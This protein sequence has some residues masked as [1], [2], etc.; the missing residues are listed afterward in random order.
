MTY[1]EIIYTVEVPDGTDAVLVPG[2]IA[3]PHGTIVEIGCDGASLDFGAEATTGQS[4]GIV[5]SP[6][7]SI[8]LRLRCDAGQVAPYPDKMFDPAPSRFTRAADDLVIEAKDA[9]GDL[10]GLARAQA[11]ARHTAE[12]FSYGHPEAR[13][14]DGC[15]VVPALGCGLTEGSC[16]DI[17]TYFLAALR[18]SGIEAGYVT[19]F[20]FPQEKKDHCTDGHCWVV[21]RINGATHEWDIAHHL[22]L[23][24]RDIAPALNPKPGQRV[25]C[26]HSM[27]L[28][29]P[30]LGGL[31]LK[32]L[33]EPVAVR[34][35]QVL[36]FKEPAIRLAVPALT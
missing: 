25:A 28:D 7:A 5:R 6:A 18:A 32:A 30:E 33:I 9:A 8:T 15:D 1:H 2:G 27:G 20:F 17:N 29:I 16:V 31:A 11:I 12:R 21:T 13:F 35:G 24:T 19:G 23:G 14:N 22:K 36:R 10:T 34:H 26:F 4:V 3:T